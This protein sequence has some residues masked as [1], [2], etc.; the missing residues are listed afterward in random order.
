MQVNLSQELGERLKGLKKQEET[1]QEV[2]EQVVQLGCWQLEYRRKTQPK[3]RE[4]QKLDREIAEK[5]RRDPELG[6]R[7]GLAHV[8]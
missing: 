8:E 4:R 6:V 5:V 1:I 2:V 3:R 7:L